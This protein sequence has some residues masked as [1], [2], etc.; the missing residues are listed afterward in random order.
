MSILSSEDEYTEEELLQVC[1]DMGLPF[2]SENINVLK[3]GRL[4]ATFH[5]SGLNAVPVVRNAQNSKGRL[6]SISSWETTQ[7]SAKFLISCKEERCIGLSYGTSLSLHPRGAAEQ[8]EC[9]GEW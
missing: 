4:D 5:L 6:Y 9:I 2:D 1:E 7:I 3:E 8:F